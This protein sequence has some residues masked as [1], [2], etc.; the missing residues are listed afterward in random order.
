[1][2]RI[3]SVL[4]I[5]ILML[6]GCQQKNAVDNLYIAENDEWICQV[7]VVQMD[8]E[9][10]YAVDYHIKYIGDTKHKDAMLKMN[11]FFEDEQHVRN[12]DV[13]CWDSATS[14]VWDSSGNYSKYS[15]IDYL[16]PKNFCVEI[17]DEKWTLEF[18]QIDEEKRVQYKSK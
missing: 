5:A 15:A 9:D 16:T 2:K 17:N 7:S 1:M 14:N 10:D 11:I 13:E 3:I 4:L 12:E 8:T 18:A 6:C